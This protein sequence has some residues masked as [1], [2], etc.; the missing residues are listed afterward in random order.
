MNWFMSLLGRNS[1]NVAEVDAN[2]QLLVTTNQ[3]PTKAGATRIYDSEGTSINVEE[4]GSLSVSQDNLIFS[5]Q[6]DG[7]AVNTNRWTTSVS[8]LAIAQ[9]AGF[10]TLNSGNVTTA[11]GYAI[12]SSILNLPFYGDLPTEITIS[13]KIGVLPQANVTM[14]LGLGYAATNAA[15]TDGAFFRWTASGA[16]EAVVNNAGSETV[17]LISPAPAAGV[18]TTFA[19][20]VAEDHVQFRVNDAL[21][22]DITNPPGISYP[23]GAGHQ[24]IFARVVTGGGPP[25]QAPYIAI[26]QVTAVQLAINQYRLWTHFLADLGLSAYQSP[27]TPFGQSANRANSSAPASLTLSNTVPSLATLGGEWQF[28]AV[29]GGNTDYAIFA[30]PVP[31]GFRLK[32]FGVRIWSAVAGIAVV[33]PA[34]LDWS[35]GINSS[36]ASLATA[37]SPPA[38]WSPRRIMV[39]AQC[40]AA[41]APVGTP[42]TDIVQRFEAPLVVDSGRYLHVAVRVANGAAT[43][44]L[45]YRGGVMIDAQFE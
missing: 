29:A 40:F 36:G 18:K 31:A 8:V 23:F 27:V 34:I 35:L 45:L 37:D 33:T 10:I 20:V 42:A 5:E 17:S 4:N 24:P 32:V 25:A 26:G 30:F 15:P 16:F 44:T 13:A 3:D 38:S 7:T 1:G 22:A 41:L 39:G 21:V 19:V 11:N 9:A 2:L 28:A 43:A 12:I 14:E 6:V